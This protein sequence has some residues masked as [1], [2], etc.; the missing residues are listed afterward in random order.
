MLSRM[1]KP[2]MR[3]I[4]FC[5]PSGLSTS[6]VTGLK[7]LFLRLESDGQAV[8]VVGKDMP[9]AFERYWLPFY[10]PA[11]GTMTPGHS[12]AMGL[13]PDQRAKWIARVEARGAQRHRV[14]SG[15]DFVRR[16][17]QGADRVFRV[18]G[19]HG[20]YLV[21]NQLDPQF[22]ILFDLAT[23]RKYLHGVIERGLIS[24]TLQ[25]DTCGFGPSASYVN[26]SLES[27]VD[28]SLS[29]HYYTVGA[30]RMNASA[31]E[32]LH[33]GNSVD[34]KLR[35]KI[36]KA[37]SQ[38][39][40]IILCFGTG[41]IHCGQFPDWAPDSKQLMP[42]F[43]SGV[44]IAEDISKDP[45]NFVLYKFHP[46]S[47]FAVPS[48][49]LKSNLI[50]VNAC[51]YQLASMSDLVVAWGTKLELI[52]FALN[53][54]LM[55]VGAGCLWNKQVAFEV[56]SK[57]ELLQMVDQAVELGIQQEMLFRIN[58]F[59]GW[60]LCTQ[61]F[62]FRTAPDSRTLAKWVSRLNSKFQE[63][64]SPIK[65]RIDSRHRYEMFQEHLAMWNCYF[66]FVQAQNKMPSFLL[67]LKRFKAVG[68]SVL[69]WLKS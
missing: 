60:L 6:I 56:R 30:T 42:V 29:E 15:E 33:G 68:K 57:H 46:K 7:A 17:E 16:A 61:L 2:Q 43:S 51:P 58:I 18:V 25:I 65:Y 23:N 44:A 59:A 54:P 27:L 8:F 10:V 64:P 52:A 67:E 28:P 4:A 62:D 47:G 49:D 63:L 55:L 40:K 53:K 31:L 5:L 1:P 26:T 14:S 45:Q 48:D 38:G 50:N 19:P 41:D 13:D 9:Q 32:V 35:R 39:K 11:F 36:E 24:E 37:R 12:D 3:P 20:L 69:G 66:R 34:R 21:W 22:G